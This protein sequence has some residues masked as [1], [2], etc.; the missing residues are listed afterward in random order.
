M[1]GV[2]RIMQAMMD[3]IILTLRHGAKIHS[4][5][6]SSFVA[7]SVIAKPFGEIAAR[8]PQLDLGSYP[9]V[10]EARFG[11]A[12]VARGTDEQA[13]H[14]AADEIRQL[15]QSQGVEIIPWEG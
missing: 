13:V 2:P 6:I 14:Q 15:V 1:A 7:E 10:K 5:T 9:W 11:T 3:N 12:L 8:Y 4:H